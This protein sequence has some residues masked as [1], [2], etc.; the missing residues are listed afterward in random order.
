MSGPGLA[1]SIETLT[2][3]SP[4]MD[5]NAAMTPAASADILTIF[6]LLSRCSIA[7][8]ADLQRDRLTGEIEAVVGLVAIPVALHHPLALRIEMPFL[9]A[10]EHIRLAG[11]GAAA[12]EMDADMLPEQDELVVAGLRHRH[13]ARWRFRTR[14]RIRDVGRIGLAAQLPLGN[15]ALIFQ[16]LKVSVCGVRA[17]VSARPSVRPSSAQRAHC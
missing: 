10:G 7:A 14:R 6:M 8:H 13:A 5:A 3:A 2:S 17:S 1:A 16:P 12:F 9:D 15:E 11:V 4:G